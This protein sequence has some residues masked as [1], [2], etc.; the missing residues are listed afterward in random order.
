MATTNL[1]WYV[2]ESHNSAGMTTCN[3]RTRAYAATP[4]YCSQD[5]WVEVRATVSVEC[6]S[7]ITLPTLWVDAYNDGICTGNTSKV[8][9]AC[10]Y[11]D[12]IYYG[13]IHSDGEVDY[14]SADIEGKS[15]VTLYGTTYDCSGTVTLYLVLPVMKADTSQSEYS[16]YISVALPDTVTYTT[17]SSAPTIAVTDVGCSNYT[18]ID[19]TRYYYSISNTLTSKLI[20]AIPGCPTYTSYSISVYQDGNLFDYGASNTLT[21]T[22]NPCTIYHPYSVEFTASNTVG[23]D[24]YTMNLLVGSAPTATLS[25]S[26]LYMPPGAEYSL[27]LRGK[28][29]GTSR[30]VNITNSGDVVNISLVNS[31]YDED[32]GD[33]E[34]EYLVTGVFNSISENI[35]FTLVDSLYGSS[36]T[37]NLYVEAGLVCSFTYAP[38]NPVIDA[39][40]VFSNASSVAEGIVHTWTIDGIS[41]PSSNELWDATLSGDNMVAIFHTNGV[42]NVTLSSIYNEGVLSNT[43]SLNVDV[44][45]SVNVSEPKYRYKIAIY[46]PDTTEFMM[47]GRTKSILANNNCVFYNLKFGYNESAPA[48]CT[49]KLLGA[50]TI[51]DTDTSA[52]LREGSRVA[53]FDDYTVVWTGIIT[54]ISLNNTT[55]PYNNS[56]VV[57]NHIVTCMD[58]T[59]ELML[60]QYTDTSETITDTIQNILIGNT[61]DGTYH[62]GILPEGSIGIIG[63]ASGSDILSQIISYAFSNIDRYSLLQQL[64][65]T[66]G[67][68]FRSRP[69]IIDKKISCEVSGTSVTFISTQDYVAGDIIFVNLGYTLDGLYIPGMMVMECD[70]DLVAGT[71]TL[72]FDSNYIHNPNQVTEGYVTVLRQQSLYDVAQSFYQ[73]SGEST[74]ATVSNTY[75]LSPDAMRTYV[76]DKD[77]NA[78]NNSASVNDKYGVVSVTSRSI[79]NTSISST[80]GGFM[81][82]NPDYTIPSAYVVVKSIDSYII[83]ANLDTRPGTMTIATFDLKGW[84]TPTDKSEYNTYG[85]RVLLPN[86]N[87]GSNYRAFPTNAQSEGCIRTITRLM[88]N[89][90]E[91]YT[92]VGFNNHI[93]TSENDTS[94]AQR[95]RLTI[96]TFILGNRYTL[97][98]TEGLSVGDYIMIGDE[99]QKITAIEG[100]DI[101]VD[102][103]NTAYNAHGHM[104]GTLVF[105]ISS[106]YGY[107]NADI[108]AGSPIAKFGKTTYTTTGPSGQTQMELEIVAQNI[109]RFGS[110]YM[111][112]GSAKIPLM[113]FGYSSEGTFNPLKVGDHISIRPSYYDANAETE[114]ELVEYEVDADKYSVSVKYG[115]PVKSMVSAIGNVSKNQSVVFNNPDYQ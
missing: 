25:E 27:F 90:N 67:W 114:F 2:H 23:S 34:Y 50:N 43:Y 8:G 115:M 87:T 68:K 113:Y 35:T 45:K 51:V 76:T 107:Q 83:S 84:T 77:I 62:K 49:F 17:S 55:S 4:T 88:G 74:V 59:Y 26:I 96:G 57:T 97:N 15:Y 78:V 6:L 24:T 14:V 33:Y 82:I 109:L 3:S 79:Q 46:R 47:I 66:T 65:E 42:Y 73:Y 75:P 12:L 72:T 94:F 36:N 21:T 70:D 40:V 106:I 86:D 103:D 81:L 32:T 41:V 100:N 60:S 102:R 7:S 48:P 9:S 110:N 5:G 92:R 31:T 69:N 29:Y 95:N 20:Q 11:H 111:D 16:R 91:K 10:G 80:I 104:V 44:G 39:S 1:Y 112:N 52:L 99:R 18:T 101:I 53:I 22:Y 13:I 61:Y 63:Y 85:P 93:G 105:K 71:H 19:S 98:T 64:V 89:D 108:E 58:A 28:S 30:T 38:P 56:H 37:L 54:D